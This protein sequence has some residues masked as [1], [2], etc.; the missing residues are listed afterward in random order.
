MTKIL[1]TLLNA[2]F[3]ITNVDDDVKVRG[4][5]YHGK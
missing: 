2:E 3:A 5:P 4:I 1:R